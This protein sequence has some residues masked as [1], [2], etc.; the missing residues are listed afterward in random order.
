MLTFSTG[1]LVLSVGVGLFGTILDE[2]WDWGKYVVAVG[3]SGVCLS[4]VCLAGCIFY[5]GVKP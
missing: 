5:Y 3:S 4:L 1:L 2:V